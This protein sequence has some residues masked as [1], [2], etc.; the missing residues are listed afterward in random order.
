VIQNTKKGEKKSS[1]AG[2]RTR[3]GRVKADNVT[4]YITRDRIRKQTEIKANKRRE[5]EEL[6]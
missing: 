5:E 1:L 2:N 3:G 4:D 6:S